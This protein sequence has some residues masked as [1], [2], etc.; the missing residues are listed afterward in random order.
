MWEYLVAECEAGRYW[1]AFYEM[2]LK[3]LG[4]QGWELVHVTERPVDNEVVSLKGY[5]KRRKESA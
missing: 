2:H 5:F 4:E 1:D 3:H